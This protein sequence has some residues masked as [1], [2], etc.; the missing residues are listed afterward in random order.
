MAKVERTAT[1]TGFRDGDRNLHFLHVNRAEK[2]RTCRACHDAHSSSVA[3]HMRESVP[4]GDWALPVGFQPTADGGSC[5][6]GCH[7]PVSYSR[8]G[9]SL[10][11]AATAGA[12]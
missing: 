8:K 4:F 11:P 5:T 9:Q 6:P 1:A 10:T 7:L 3:N 2:G 12:K